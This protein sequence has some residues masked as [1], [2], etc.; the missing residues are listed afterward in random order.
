MSLWFLEFDWLRRFPGWLLRGWPNAAV[1]SCCGFECVGGD[2]VLV[3]GLCL[4]MIRWWFVLCRLVAPVFR[5][6]VIVR[7]DFMVSF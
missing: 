2:Y 3:D 7:F 6:L 1:L 4:S 5:F